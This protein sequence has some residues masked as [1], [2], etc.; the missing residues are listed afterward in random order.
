VG[1]QASDWGGHPGFTATVTVTNPG[2]T[3]ITGWTVGFSYTAGQDV[4]E[5]GWNATVAQNG[6]AVTAVNA[7]WNGTLAPGQSTSFGFNGLATAIGN[8]PP[9]TGLACTTG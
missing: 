6:S 1:Y 4:D 3:S 2:G 7:A 9:P 5:P 8:N